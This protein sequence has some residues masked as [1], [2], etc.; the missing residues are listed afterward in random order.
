MI[1]QLS[2]RHVKN[3]VNRKRFLGVLG[4]V[5]AGIASVACL[6][7]MGLLLRDLMLKDNAGAARRTTVH[8]RVLMDRYDMYMTNHISDALGSV[9]EVEKVYWLRDVEPVAPEP[10]PSKYGATRDPA[11]LQWLLD[12]AQELLNGQ[13]TLFTPQTRVM[14]KSTVDY[15]LD[16]TILSISWKQFIGDACY[17]FN[18]VVVAHPSQIRRFL[19]DGQY[20]S[21][22]RYL[23]TQMSDA[24]NAVSATNGDYYMFRDIGTVV[25]NGKVYR[26]DNTLDMCFI[27]GQGDMLLVQDRTFRTKGE[28]ER[29]VEEKDIRFSLAFGPI[30]I[31]D[32]RIVVPSEYEIGEIKLNYSRAALAQLGERHYLVAVNSLEGDPD[33]FPTLWEFARVL[34]N[35]GCEKAYALDGGQTAVLVMNDQMLSIPS[36][37]N[38]RAV[39]DMIY[40]ATALPNSG[41]E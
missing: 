29:F 17:Y 31:D 37:G 25:Y 41:K 16:E 32:Y 6:A 9:M 28:V 2:M 34:Q 35:C 1:E 22:R 33:D 11:S 39:S 12:D 8:D 24:V 27:D 19:A 30:M 23:T 18:E 13:T 26:S 10:D 3:A 21:D 40:F 15:Y 5:V 36:Y 14:W 4:R 20:G 38:Q 7:V